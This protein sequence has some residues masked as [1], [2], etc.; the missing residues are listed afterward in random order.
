MRYGVPGP[1]VGIPRYPPSTQ[2]VSR[3]APVGVPQNLRGLTLLPAPVG[4]LAQAINTLESHPFLTAL[5]SASPYLK[6]LTCLADYAPDLP[7]DL[8]KSIKTPSKWKKLAAGL[9][10]DPQQRAFL[11][12]T[13]AVDLIKG[14][15]KVNA[16]P[17]EAE[18]TR[19]LARLLQIGCLTDYADF[20]CFSH[21][22]LPYRFVSREKHLSIDILSVSP[23][24]PLAAPRPLPRPRPRLLRRSC[25]SLTS[26]T[27]SL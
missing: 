26:T 3:V 17:E 21:C 5:T 24:D 2:G 16:L 12:T 20:T 25:P 1:L 15:V 7:K 23:L 11:G 14:G 10:K 27:S 8:R 4:L 6:Y 19:R 13:Q 18:G 22:Q 9:S